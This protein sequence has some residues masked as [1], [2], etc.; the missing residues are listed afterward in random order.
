VDWLIWLGA[1]AGLAILELLGMEL[2]L[3]MLSVGCLAACL[4]SLGSDSW[5][6]EGI[7]AGAVSIAMLGLVRPGLIQR[8]HH[9]PELRLGPAR[10]VGL[11]AHVDELI[12]AQHPGQ[13]IVGGEQ[14][15]A[16]PFDPTLIIEPG[17]TV[18][19][20]QVEGATAYVH[21]AD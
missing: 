10:L 4:V 13:I 6:V 9:G 20:L 2:V 14:W 5:V 3:L 16:K 11:H 18:E 21:P 7:V 1:A 17:T 19:V 15:T 8:L 12:S